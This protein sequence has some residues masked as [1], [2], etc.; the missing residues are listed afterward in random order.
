MVSTRPSATL[1]SLRE[2]HREFERLGSRGECIE[3][4]DEL[5][6]LLDC[7]TV[8]LDEEMLGEDDLD[9]EM[10]DLEDHAQVGGIFDL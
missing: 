2:V 7:A 5:F 10:P 4:S 3:V 1:P 6:P 9:D 8:D